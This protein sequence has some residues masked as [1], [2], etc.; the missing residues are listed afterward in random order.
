MAPDGPVGG[1]QLRVRS[2]HF[3]PTWTPGAF[4]VG[5]PVLGRPTILACQGLKTFPECG[6]FS[7]KT[8]TGLSQLGGLVPQGL[9]E[10]MAPGTG[11]EEP[12]YSAMPCLV[13]R[14]DRGGRRA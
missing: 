1:P 11:L 12:S 4:P 6:S 9:G 10:A 8:T 7:A 3:P 5:L 2:Q 14:C 13:R